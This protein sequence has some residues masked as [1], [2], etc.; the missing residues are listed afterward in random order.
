MTILILIFQK[1]NDNS[2]DMG[3]IQTRD[4][5]HGGTWGDM[6]ANLLV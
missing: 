5:R 4:N 6:G 1:V 3:V 2:T